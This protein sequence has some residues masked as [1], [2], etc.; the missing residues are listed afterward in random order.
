MAPRFEII[1]HP[2]DVGFL[3]YGATLSKLFENAGLA[4]CSLTCAPEKIEERLERE[5]FSRGADIESL[6]YEWLTE[7]LAVADAE[8]IAGRRV[9]IEFFRE[10]QSKISG[11][12]R[13]ILRGEKFDRERHS[14]GTYIKGVTLHQFQVERTPAGFRARVFLDL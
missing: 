9:D 10:P 8:Q 6:L 2:A 14:A 5:I 11:E 3:A 4:L 13:G 1:E 7:I 12:A